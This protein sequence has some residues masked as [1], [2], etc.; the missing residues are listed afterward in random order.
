MRK[1]A[2]ASLSARTGGRSN[3]TMEALPPLL[4][5][6]PH[7][8]I[9]KGPEGRSEVQQAV[10]GF[11][12]LAGATLRPSCLVSEGRKGGGC[13]LRRGCGVGGECA[14]R[15]GMADSRSRQ[16]VSMGGSEG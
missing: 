7:T 14:L 10:T 15:R 6:H 8:H 11:G 3:E 4:V 9:H 1:R 2:A 13:V 16:P 5:R 12:V